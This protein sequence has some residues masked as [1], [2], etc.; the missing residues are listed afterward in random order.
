MN[1]NT[2]FPA[3]DVFREIERA[4]FEDSTLPFALSDF[5][6][7]LNAALDRVGF[8]ENYLKTEVV[9]LNTRKESSEDI[10]RQGSSVSKVVKDIIWGMIELD[11]TTVAILDTPILQRLRYVR[12]NGFTYLVYP[13]AS[14]VRMEH[15]LGVLAVVSKYIASINASAVQESRFAPGLVA[16]SMPQTLALDLKHAAILHDIGHFPLSHVLETIFESD[17]TRFKIGGVLIR[18]FEICIMSRLKDLKSRLSEKL[19]I[20]II[21]SPRFREFYTALRKDPW[22]YLRVACLV[23]GTPLSINTPGY[24]Q[25]ISGAVDCDKVDYLLRDSAMCNVPV[26]IDQARLFL[27]S[28]LIECGGDT[29]RKLSEKGVLSLSTDLKHP[30][31][32]LVLN[33][34]GVDTIEEVAFARATLYERVYRHPVTRNA[35]R[36]LSVAICDAASNGDV[37]EGWQ[38]ALQSFTAT[39]DT[40]ID[41]L[42]KSRSMLAAQLTWNLRR[43]QLPKRAFAFSPDFYAPIVPYVSVFSNL[44]PSEAASTYYHEVTSKDP[45]HEIVQ[46]LK[47]RSDVFRSN[48]RHHDLEDRIVT[49][50]RRIAVKLRE[51]SAE[52]PSEGPNVFFVPL[53]DHS[54]TPTSCAIV[55]HEGELES[56]GDYSRAAQLVIGRSVGFVTCD[57]KWAEIVFLA[58]QAVLYDYFGNDV[59]QMDL[60]LHF[61]SPDDEDGGDVVRPNVLRLKAV[62]RFY[63][64]ED[65]AVR[66]CRLDRRV[67]TSHRSNL[68]RAGYYDSKPRLA[69]GERLTPGIEQIAGKFREFSGQHGW[70]VTPETLRQFLNQ[71]PPRYRDD[72]KTLLGSFNFL[73]RATAS[74]LLWE[75]IATTVVKIREGKAAKS[76]H[77]VPLAG[78]SAHMMLELSKQEN[79]QQLRSLGL[80]DRRSIHETLGIAKPGD[81]IIFVD[82]NVSS[83]TQFSA[84]LLRWIGLQK[85]SPDDAVRRE[86]GIE[87]FELEPNAKLLL[88]GLEIRLATC[89]GKS[90]SEAFVRKNLEIAS[91]SLDFCGLSFGKE[92]TMASSSSLESNFREFLARVGTECMRSARDMAAADDD[93]RS[94]ALGYG[95]SEGRTVTLW[96]V[97]TSTI[98]AFWC[99]G[100]VDGEPWFPLFIRRGYADKLVVA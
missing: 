51:L 81:A 3:L 7:G 53:P 11:R 70:R 15:S 73:N 16:K 54:S 72:A 14:H 88:S 79:R 68:S 43:R 94:K 55:T 6:D 29:V 83:G 61:E 62:K 13:A 46:S 78:T 36:I 98:T 41:R 86:D 67:L 97:P 60:N 85:D 9:K 65:L 90:G 40:F 75:A 27:N 32:T 31:L 52:V 2:V 4:L 23:S 64:A 71:F 48:A 91:G 25:L 58:A 18:D 50:A 89:V 49:E 87:S 66:R 19:S 35:E 93:C 10:E 22:A 38:E 82:D 30:A 95:N 80:H 45:F 92:L 77:V 47:E 17:P 44:S 84:Q 99:P 42:L 37:S 1:D 59:G 20:A 57:P 74:K 96:N 24:S 28:A 33:S 39:D 34:S 21:L 100:I 12:Q 5:R 26:A 63:I 56:S 76:I 8:T 69:E